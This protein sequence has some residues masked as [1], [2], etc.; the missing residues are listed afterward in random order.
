MRQ[1]QGQRTFRVGEIGQWLGMLFLIVGIVLMVIDNSAAGETIIAI[2]A[3]AYAVFTKVKY[4]TGKAEKNAQSKHHSD[5]ESESVGL[6]RG[7]DKRDKLADDD[8]GGGHVQGLLETGSS[9]SHD[10]SLAKCCLSIG[11][12][13]RSGYGLGLSKRK[14]AVSKIGVFGVMRRTKKN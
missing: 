1:A 8:S 4:Y 5:S 10:W 11:R 7:S 12:L 3:L 9:A 14:P 13:A 6:E 2:S